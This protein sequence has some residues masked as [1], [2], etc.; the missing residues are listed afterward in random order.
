MLALPTDSQETCFYEYFSL[1]IFLK[2]FLSHCRQTAR[3]H[4]FLRILFSEYFLANTF[5]SLLELATDSWKTWLLRTL[6][7]EY[8]SVIARIGY[9]QLGN[10]YSTNAF[11][12]LLEMATDWAGKHVFCE[13]FSE[14]L[15]E[16]AGKLNRKWVS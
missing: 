7:S 1:N 11:Q 12:S 10:M 14:R 5:Q 13:W 2:I 8:F 16:F 4:V 15:D 6:F 9:R 3:K